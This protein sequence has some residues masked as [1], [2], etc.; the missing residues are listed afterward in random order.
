MADPNLVDF[1]DRV[2]RFERARAHGWAHQTGGMPE[3]RRI[4][5]TRRRRSFL[6]PLLLVAFAVFAMKGAIL[7]SVGAS[8][9]QDRVARLEA[10]EGFDRL[11]AWMMQADPLT[12]FMAGQIAHAMLQI[13]K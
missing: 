10:G 8:A 2:S 4:R 13:Q 12:R 11:G 3:P 9:Y 6:V 1:Y 5:G 7:Y